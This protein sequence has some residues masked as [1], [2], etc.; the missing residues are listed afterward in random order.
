MFRNTSCQT[1]RAVFACVMRAKGLKLVFNFS[2]IFVVFPQEL[3]EMVKAK[4]AAQAAV[5]RK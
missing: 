2:I 5:G 1:S 4:K 3:V